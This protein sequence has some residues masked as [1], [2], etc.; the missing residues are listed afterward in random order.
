MKLKSPNDAAG[1]FKEAGSAYKKVSPEG[2]IVVMC[3]TESPLTQSTSRVESVQF[4]NQAIELYCDNGRF[5]TAAKVIFSTSISSQCMSN[6]SIFFVNRW[7]GR[8]VKCVKPMM[9]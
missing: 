9:S 1:S 3:S 6:R 5:A 2:S 8:S 7:R 4:F